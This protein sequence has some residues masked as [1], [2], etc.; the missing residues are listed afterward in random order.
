MA[1]NWTTEWP[2]VYA[3]HSD[4]CPLRTGGDCTCPQVTYRASARTPDNRSRALSPEF[5]TAIDAR[6]WLRDQRARVTAALAVADEGPVV[7]ALIHEFLAA[8][9]P[10][11][12]R[13]GLGYVNAE[14]GRAHVQAVRRRDVQAVVEGLRATGMSPDRLAAVVEAM[15]ELFTYAVQRD[16]VDVNPVGD[17][18]TPVPPAH[19]LNGNG[20]GGHPLINGEEL[21]GHS[22]NGNGTGVYPPLAATAASQPAYTTPLP[23]FTTP[24]PTYTT[25][26]PPAFTTP[27]PAYETPPPPFT[28]PQPAY[29]SPQPA[30]TTPPPAYTTPPPAYAAE[31]AA[32]GAVTRFGTPTYG[33]EP[34][35]P[36]T[37]E[38]APASGGESFVMSE[39]MFWWITRIVVIVFVLIA[40]V[41]AAESV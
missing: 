4:A 30:Y 18:S 12:I 16:L 10:A 36:P 8:G 20:T 32:I 11:E 14:M 19:T 40:L 15:R 25:P 17:N 9:A 34:A 23:A 21:A 33:S 41:L 24:Q 27:Q 31:P 1:Y 26:P 29:T 28:A 22:A 6:D 3:R 5:P 13:D 39:Q 2:G 38:A 37:A 35:V 7:T